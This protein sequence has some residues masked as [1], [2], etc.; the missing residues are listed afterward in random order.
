MLTV[1]N[2]IYL[3][4]S[5]RAHTRRVPSKQ[6]AKWW[7]RL[8]RNRAPVVHALFLLYVRTTIP[9]RISIEPWTVTPCIQNALPAYIYHT[10]VST[11]CTIE[12]CYVILLGCVC[13]SKKCCV[14][15]RL[16]SPKCIPHKMHIQRLEII[17][18][19]VHIQL[20]IFIYRLEHVQYSTVV[21]QSYICACMSST[22]STPSPP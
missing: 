20:Y 4:L 10:Y 21:V 7:L 16:P 2:I 14:C 19:Y 9:H 5:S 6:Q 8:N 3:S 1:T 15:W 17:H 11:L 22:G 13:V 18:T 12:P